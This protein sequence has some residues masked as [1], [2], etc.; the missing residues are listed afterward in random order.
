MRKKSNPRYAEGGYT[1]ILVSQHPHLTKEFESPTAYCP[2]IRHPIT[3]I[4]RHFFTKDLGGILLSNTDSIITDYTCYEPLGKP[5]GSCVWSLPTEPWCAYRQR[6]N[7]T[8]NRGQVMTMLRDDVVCVPS[9]IKTP[10]LAIRQDAAVCKD[11][12]KRTAMCMISSGDC[13]LSG[14]IDQRMG[15]KTFV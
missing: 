7:G 8:T 15:G 1:R 13:N 4:L 6:S 5:Q 12:D 14:E 10:L 2:S 11:V 3:D 9:V